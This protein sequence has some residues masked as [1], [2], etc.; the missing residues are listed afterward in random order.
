MFDLMIL[1]YL[2]FSFGAFY[3]CLKY[4]IKIV[5]NIEW[6]NKVNSDWIDGGCLLIWSYILDMELEDK[7]ISK[8]MNNI[9]YVSRWKMWRK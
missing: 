6:N 9:E 2:K 5:F 1:K 4:I 3:G 8:W 7:L